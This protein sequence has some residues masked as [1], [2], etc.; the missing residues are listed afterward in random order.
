MPEES[1]HPPTESEAVA[2]H[3][4]CSAWWLSGWTRKRDKYSASTSD[5]LTLCVVHGRQESALMRHAWSG[6]ADAV[7]AL[8]WVMKKHQSQLICS[9]CDEPIT[10]D[11][12]CDC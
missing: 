2:L 5:P 3:R 1:K 12:M 7:I 11:G 9:S 6:F 10:P 8:P 4:P